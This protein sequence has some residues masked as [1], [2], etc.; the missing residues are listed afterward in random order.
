MYIVNISAILFLLNISAIFWYFDF[1]VGYLNW[2]CM[3]MYTI[4]FKSFIFLVC[5]LMLYNILIFE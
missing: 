5:S 4:I 1:I 2:K 3:I